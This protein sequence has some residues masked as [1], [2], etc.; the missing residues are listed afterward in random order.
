MVRWAL[1]RDEDRFPVSTVYSSITVPSTLK[2]LVESAAIRKWS[3]YTPSGLIPDCHPSTGARAA[4]C[5]S[6]GDEVLL[7]SNV[8]D[9][10]FIVDEGEGNA[11]EDV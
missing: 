11:G 9:V 10:V 8:V 5:A 3:T 1:A 7:D 2:T 6:V 4:I